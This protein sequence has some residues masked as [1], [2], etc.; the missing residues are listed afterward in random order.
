MELPGL[1]HA[2]EGT[3]PMPLHRDDGLTW[4]ASP[5]CATGSCLEIAAAEDHVLLRDSAQPGVPPLKVT[6]QD[7]DAFEQGLR[8]G[9]FDTLFGH[10]Q[11]RH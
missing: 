6:R 11:G 2:D 5:F 4:H 10:D 7:W 3:G 9:A 1:T 8:A